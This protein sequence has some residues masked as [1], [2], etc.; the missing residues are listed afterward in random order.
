MATAADFTTRARG[1]MF[2][3][4]QQYQAISRR[5][6]DLTD[7]VAAN[8]GATGLYG[9]NGVNFPAQGDGFSYAD[10]VAAFTALAA[11]VPTPTQAQKNAI[12]QCRRE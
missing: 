6:A 10:M 2:S 9:T 7:E 8:G 3:I 11:L 4:Y 1:E 12:I 5:V